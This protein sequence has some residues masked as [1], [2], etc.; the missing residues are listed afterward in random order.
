M[1]C[2]FCFAAPFSGDA[3]KASA[4]T[5]DDAEP[6]AGVGLSIGLV[7]S[8]DGAS[9]IVVQGVVRG[10]S[11]SKANISIHDVVLAVDGTKVQGLTMDEIVA[12]IRGKAGS[13]VKITV[14]H[15]GTKRTVI[16]ARKSL[17][18]STKTNDVQYLPD[19]KQE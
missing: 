15:E 3:K 10:S 14:L 6:P 13:R 7:S 16:L 18:R 2:C 1:A 12:K 19:G 5:S 4:S 11:A 17:P 9:G 8:E